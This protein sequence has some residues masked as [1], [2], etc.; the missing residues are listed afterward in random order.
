MVHEPES[1]L[2]DV[3]RVKRYRDPPAPKVLCI[4]SGGIR[5]RE[6][7]NLQFTA[8]RSLATSTSSGIRSPEYADDKLVL[9]L[10]L[11]SVRFLS[12]ESEGRRCDDE[13]EA[14]LRKAPE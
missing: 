1:R 4:S 14:T 12:Q 6:Y 13:V 2:G 8:R 3:I 11:V 9:R 10:V 5:S 7:V